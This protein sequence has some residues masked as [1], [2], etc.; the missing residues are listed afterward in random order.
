MGPGGVERRVG[1]ERLVAREEG[2]KQELVLVGLHQG[3]TRRV[4]RPWQLS[5]ARF[6]G[7]EGRG[8]KKC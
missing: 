2:E 3:L 4:L 6:T 5:W 8:G 1:G 7:Q